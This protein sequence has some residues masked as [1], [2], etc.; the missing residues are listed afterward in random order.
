MVVRKS[1]VAMKVYN[2]A[3]DLTHIKAVAE[4]TARAFIITLLIRLFLHRHSK[5]L[6]KS[7]H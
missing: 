2:T 4:I 6:H 5:L 1:E 7:S 3:Q